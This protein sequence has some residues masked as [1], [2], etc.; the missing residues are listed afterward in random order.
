[1]CIT[2]AVLAVVCSL[3]LIGI[4]CVCFKRAAQVF[5][6]RLDL[7]Q[8]STQLSIQEVSIYSISHVSER[9]QRT[10]VKMPKF[11]LQIPFINLVNLQWRILSQ[12]FSLPWIS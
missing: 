3:L 12:A 6:Q 4:V 1:M 7:D 2:Y 11:K 9:L 10:T 5:K 8:E